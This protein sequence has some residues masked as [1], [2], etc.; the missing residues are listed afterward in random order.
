M[1]FHALVLKYTTFAIIVMRTAVQKSATVW[2][3]PFGLDRL[4]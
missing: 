3:A 2:S 4:S 1:T